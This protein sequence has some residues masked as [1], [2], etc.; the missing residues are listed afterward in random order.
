[1]A[2]QVG[3]RIRGVGG[4]V[5]GGMWVWGWERSTLLGGYPNPLYE[6]LQAYVVGIQGTEFTVLNPTPMWKW[7]L[8]TTPCPHVL[9]TNIPLRSHRILAGG[10][11]C[12]HI[13]VMAHCEHLKKQMF[14]LA[15]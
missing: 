4:D 12:Q 2:I 5:G 15:L 9:T 8:I 6:T 10:E 13:R 3:L 14:A 7:S 11:T 1:M